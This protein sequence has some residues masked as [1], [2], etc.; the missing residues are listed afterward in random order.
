MFNNFSMD[1]QY[2]PLLLKTLFL[3]TLQDYP[4][5]KRVDGNKNISS[6]NLGPEVF[7][8]SEIL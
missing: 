3:N 7:H 6:W 4:W 8:G 1:I 5:K 2:S